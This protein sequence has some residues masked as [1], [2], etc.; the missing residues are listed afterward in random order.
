MVGR[1]RFLQTF[2]EDDVEYRDR[3]VKD[4]DQVETPGMCQADERSG[5]RD[6]EIDRDH[7]AL[8][9]A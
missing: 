9:L 6:D 7:A 1:I 5:I 4:L 3:S 8:R 2:Q